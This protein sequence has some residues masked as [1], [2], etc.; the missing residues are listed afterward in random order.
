LTGTPSRVYLRRGKYFLS[1]EE[2]MKKALVSIFC[3]LSLLLAAGCTS[4]APAKTAASA[5]DSLETVQA[6]AEQGD[7]MSQFQL[8]LDFSNGKGVPQDWQQAYFWLSL[9][10]NA[11][12]R[13]SDG[14]Y[15][16]R[17]YAALHLTA[18]QVAAIDRQVA[19][20][21]PAPAPV[22]SDAEVEKAPV[23]PETGR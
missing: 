17:N 16:G 22:T 23:A 20:W 12:Q 2:N 21:K 6:Q 10:A 14:A 7:T 15:M 13:E 19:A 11:N 3:M 4:P 9:A 1:G 5:K 8:G 18:A